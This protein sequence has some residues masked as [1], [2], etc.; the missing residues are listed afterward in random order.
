MHYELFVLVLDYGITFV[1]TKLDRHVKKI[2]QI[3]ENEDLY[4]LL[5]HSHTFT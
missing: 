4:T 2:D 5:N 1:L 3:E